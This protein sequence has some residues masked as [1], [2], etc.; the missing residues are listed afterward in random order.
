MED[1]TPDFDIIKY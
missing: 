1:Y